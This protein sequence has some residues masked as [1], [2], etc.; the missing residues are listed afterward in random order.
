MDVMAYRKRLVDAL[1]TDHAY[2][3]ANP[4]PPSRR[5]MRLGAVLVDIGDMTP[6]EAQ[7]AAWGTKEYRERLAK[8]KRDDEDL[9]IPSSARSC[10]CTYCRTVF[11]EQRCPTCGAGREER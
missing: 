9:F 8:A 4:V 1:G 3:L 7:E 5:T 10:R 2:L 6:A 11:E